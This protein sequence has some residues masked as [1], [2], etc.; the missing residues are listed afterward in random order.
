M[1]REEKLDHAIGR[2]AETLGD[3]IVRGTDNDVAKRMIQKLDVRL[4]AG[5]S[6]DK[7]RRR[8]EEETRAYLPEARRKLGREQP[9]GKLDEMDMLAGEVIDACI[10]GERPDLVQGALRLCELCDRG[11]ATEQLFERMEGAF[12]RRGYGRELAQ[13]RQLIRETKAEFAS[14]MQSNE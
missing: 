4:L 10:R 14:I 12:L 1:T 7:L 8:V 6:F 3:A 5:M 13:L 9:V 2:I 11:F